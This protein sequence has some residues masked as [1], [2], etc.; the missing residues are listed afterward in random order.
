MPASIDAQIAEIT[1]LYEEDQKSDRL[2][3]NPGDIPISYEAIT[4]EWLTNVLCN[5]TA[6]AKVTG[7]RLDKADDGSSNRRR[8]FIEYNDAG[9]EAGL[10]QSVFCKAS[11]DLLNRVM[12]GV[13]DCA[14]TEIAFYN[15]VR[16]EMNID[17]PKG[18]FAALDPKSF[19]SIVMLEDLGPSV[20]FGNHKTEMNLERGLSQVNLLANFHSQFYKDPRLTDGSLGLKSWPA[21]WQNQVENELETYANLGFLAAEEVMSPRL[22]ARYKE[23]WSATAKSVELHAGRPQTL[24]HCDV[25]LKNWYVRDGKTMGLSDWQ[26]ASHGHWSRDIA[27]TIST[28]F[29]VEDRRK[30]EVELFTTYCEAMKSGGVDMPDMDTAWKYFRQ[31]L[32]AALAFWTVTLRHPPSMPDMQPLD[33][34]MEFLR[35]ICA[36]I[37]DHDAFAAFD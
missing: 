20:V 14:R 2:A 7:H 9:R 16:P 22:F 33:V 34:T 12:L 4:D 32:F 3:V 36:A 37:D 15:N 11:F 21:M 28:A 35:R 1:R 24:T 26:V 29:E 27:Y 17:A 13:S 31:Q 5:S 8:I 23:V 6:G 30:Y 18:L 25:H 10:P 19:A